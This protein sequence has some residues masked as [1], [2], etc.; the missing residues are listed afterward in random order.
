MRVLRRQQ[1]QLLQTFQDGIT[2]AAQCCRD[3]D[4]AVTDVVPALTHILQAK[5]RPV[6][7]ELLTLAEQAAYQNLVTVLVSL[8]LNFSRVLD[9]PAQLA[10]GREE[11]GVELSLDPD[12]TKL[13]VFGASDQAGPA[14]ADKQA[15]PDDWMVLPGRPLLPLAVRQALRR[16]VLEHRIRT[17]VEVVASGSSNGGVAGGGAVAGPGSSS[18]DSKGAVPAESSA[19]T[20]AAAPQTA[21]Q[22]SDQGAADAEMDTSTEE[23]PAGG[24]KRVR[25]AGG[26][27]APS[28]TWWGQLHER[29]DTTAK[30]RAKQQT[31]RGQGTDTG[32]GPRKV[33]FK[34]QKGFTNAVR[35]PVLMRDLL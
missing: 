27:A 2:T 20:G 29:A 24:T 1:E 3:K 21:G 10:T 31:G 25:G 32:S 30:K 7:P 4:A 5:I 35:R 14:A 8:G 13:T 19:R 9:S 11:G 34:F 23:V 28:G 18:A 15:S 12:I 17:Q 16:D 26:A 33:K 6:N 22:S